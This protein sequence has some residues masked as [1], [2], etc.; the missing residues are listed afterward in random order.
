MEKFTQTGDFC[1]DEARPGY[2]RKSPRFIEGTFCYT[3]FSFRRDRRV[4][5]LRAEPIP[6]AARLP[7]A[8]D[9]LLDVGLHRRQHGIGHSLGETS[10]RHGLL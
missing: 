8:V 10:I 5:L 6:H 1:P 7:R 9:V 4:V 2:S 3:V